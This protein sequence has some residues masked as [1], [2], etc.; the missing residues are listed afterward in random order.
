MAKRKPKPITL[1]SLNTFLVNCA[2]WQ[3]AR[4]PQ[5]RFAYRVVRRHA[6]WVDEKLARQEQPSGGASWVEKVVK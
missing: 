5:L 1:Q 4:D 6:A 3:S 2:A